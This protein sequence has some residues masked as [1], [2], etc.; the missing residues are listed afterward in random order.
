MSMLGLFKAIRKSREATRLY[1]KQ[2]NKHK[3]NIVEGTKAASALEGVGRETQRQVSRRLDEFAE[4]N[5][6]GAAGVGGQLARA[7]GFAGL[8]MGASSGIS[9]FREKFGDQMSGGANFT[10]GAIGVAAG[11]TGGMAGITHLGRAGILAQPST[12][13]RLDKLL[14]NISLL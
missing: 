2:L 10:L 14:Q 5:K 13:L 4:A 7:V 3:Q 12:V 9:S 1:G 11:F 6:F 8:G